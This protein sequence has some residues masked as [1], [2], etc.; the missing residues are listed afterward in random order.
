MKT[1]DV[2]VG[3]KYMTKVGASLV[4][5]KVTG[6]SAG[7]YG[8]GGSHDGPKRFHVARVD[9]GQKLPKPRTAAALRPVTRG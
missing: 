6:E 3:E 9:N 5:V 1:K 4:L 2:K 8:F 7:A